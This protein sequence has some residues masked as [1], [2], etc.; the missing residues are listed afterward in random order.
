MDGIVGM[1][2][3]GPSA[4]RARNVGKLIASTNAVA[5]DTVASAMMGVSP[6]T[7]SHLR[8]A[9]ERGWGPTDIN[10]IEIEG[11]FEKIPDWKMPTTFKTNLGVL[12]FNRAL[13]YLI[14]NDK[15]VVIKKECTGCGVC[16]EACPMGAIRIINEK[17]K[18]LSEKC[19]RCYCC[20]ELCPQSAIRSGG[21]FG[22]IQRMAR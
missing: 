16:K 4:G 15:V 6:E 19:V 3:D 13:G 18:I 10:N 5:V 1:D 22:F 12:V 20:H 17:A 8:I 11:A 2:K 9:G 7:I 14:K 21:L